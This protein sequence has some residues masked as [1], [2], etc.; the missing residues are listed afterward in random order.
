MR[1]RPT[2]PS[3]TIRLLAGVLIGVTGTGC[4]AVGYSNP[5]NEDAPIKSWR[6]E[7]P[8]ERGAV[9]RVTQDGASL[10][11]SV[12]RACDVRETAKVRRT[13]RRDR[14]NASPA[15]DWVF[16]VAGVGAAG[17]G[18]A[19]LLDASKVAPN[20]Q[21]SRQYNSVGPGNARLI[22]A[23][24]IAA[25]VA[26]GSVV[27]VDLV[28]TH[29]EQRETSVVDVPG[30]TVDRG[31]PCK[32]RPLVGVPVALALPGGSGPVSLGHTDEHGKL[33]VQLDKAL[34][35]D[36]PVAATGEA[37]VLVAG[38]KAGTLSL[39]PLHSALERAAWKGLY[40]EGCTNPHS[41]DA[42]KSVKDFLR[43]FPEGKHANEAKQLL[44]E[45]A[46]AIQRMRDEKAWKGVDPAACSNP[47]HLSQVEA[48]CDAVK[49]YLDAFPKGEHADAARAALKK[50]EPLVAKQRKKVAFEAALT[51]AKEKREEKAAEAKEKAEEAKAARKL[52]ACVRRQCNAI[53]SVKCPYSNRCLNG[54]IQLCV[55]S[56][57]MNYRCGDSE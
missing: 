4:A 50:G 27:V 53:C 26:L 17:A 37:A 9:A 45:A 40:Q 55:S 1:P 47:K 38:A 21:T 30:E 2:F 57:Q 8:R 56:D 48:A 39:A 43:R 46:P 12:A 11:V 54:C 6:Q 49:Q 24:L 31:V 15:V 14:V 34:P 22:G 20:D 33:T 19:V 44:H 13:T 16:G 52:K 35:G 5:R 18:V 10:T 28:R 7:V 41:V 25:G 51:Q 3:S 32:Q 36:A 23:G 29:G 42:C